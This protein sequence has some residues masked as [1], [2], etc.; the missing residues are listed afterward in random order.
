MFTRAILIVLDGVGVGALPDAAEYGDTGSNTLAHVAEHSPLQLPA[1]RTLGLSQ[2]VDLGGDRHRDRVAGAFGRMRERSAGKDSVTGHW[3]LMGVTL[4]QPFPV[5]PDGFPPALIASLEQRIGRSSLGNVV[6][7]GTRVLEVFG[8][9]HL[10]TGQPIV[11]TSADSV[12]QIAAHEAIVPL[13]DLYAWCDAAFDVAVRGY[14][15]G[16]VIA[17]PF[18]GEAP[19]F[20]R[21][22][23][24]HD[25][26]MPPPRETLL[27]SLQHS[28]ITVTCIGKVADLFARRS[29]GRVVSTASD[30]DGMQQ[31]R[32]VLDRQAD[33]LVFANLVDFDTV[34]GHRNDAHGFARNLEAFDAWLG[35]EVECLRAGDLMVITADHGNDPTMPSTDHSREYVPL[36]AAARRLAQP[37]DLGERQTFA[38]VGQTLAELFAV[39]SLSEGT[40]FLPQLVSGS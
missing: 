35:S 38:D 4:E 9:E 21:T 30:A 23:N 24:R 15:L 28:G 6:M 22:A 36:L 37:V 1:L 3:E 18:V 33:G 5:F 10:R 39:P 25:F 2:V 8:E 32:A 14:G 31:L 40:S 19:T 16:R 12:L 11:Y 29:T 26:A 34:Y 17:R 7:S 27:D 13:Q 20:I